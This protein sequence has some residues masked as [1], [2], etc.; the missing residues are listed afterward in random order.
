MNKNLRKQNYRKVV[1]LFYIFLTTPNEV[2]LNSSDNCI[3]DCNMKNVN[4]CN[5]ELQ[6]INTKPVI[7]GT[8]TDI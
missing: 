5:P 1:K 4:Y 2:H 6:L 7:K 8:S 3:D